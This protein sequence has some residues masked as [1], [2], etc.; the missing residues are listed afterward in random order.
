MVEIVW[1]ISRDFLDGGFFDLL[2]KMVGCCFV[3]IISILFLAFFLSQVY[4]LL[5]ACSR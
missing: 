1:N 5:A 4:F 2:E 3:R